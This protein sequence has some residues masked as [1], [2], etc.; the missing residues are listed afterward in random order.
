MKKNVLTI[1]CII[2]ICITVITIGVT[3]SKYVDE[4]T[5]TVE[6][7]VARWNIKLNNT[8]IT[9][10]NTYN[11]VINNIAINGNQNVA[12]G[13]IAPG[14]SGYFDINIDPSNTDVSVKYE[15]TIDPENFEG[16]NIH[17]NNV[18]EVNN[19]TLIQTPSSLSTA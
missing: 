14:M 18:H 7:N 12:E 15:L 2:S 10:G 16:S 6:N 4:A 9:N 5:G 11:F 8:D 3:Y 17:I 13:K 19:N 1:L